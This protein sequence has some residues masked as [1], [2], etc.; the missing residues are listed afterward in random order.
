M[1]DQ[2]YIK[3]LS[4]IFYFLFLFVTVVACDRNDSKQFDL[5]LSSESGIDF[6]NKVV[7]GDDANI[8]D[9]LYFYNGGGVSIGDINN[10]SLPDLF[11]I[12]NQQSNA[13]YLNQGD[14]K[15]KNITDQAKVGGHSDWNTGSVMADVN[16]DGFL[17]IYVM[18]VVGVCGFDGR[19]E[20]YINQGDGTFKEEA[21]R[22]GL[23]FDSYSG[24]AAFFDYDKDGDLDMYLLNQA[25]HTTSSYG[26]ATLRYQHNYVSG[27]KLMENQG[28][29]FVDVSEKAGLLGGPIGYG[30]GLGIADFN[31]DG[32]DDIYVGN[33]FHEDDYYYINNG[34]GTFSEQLKKHFGMVSRFSMGND[35]ADINGDGFVD[36]ITLDI[37]PE[38]EK[39]LKASKGDEP[40]DLQKRRTKLGYHPQYM[41]NMLQIN[42]G[43][44]F[45]SEKALISGVAASDWSWSPLFADL[46]QDGIIDLFITTGIHRRPN[47]LDY[48]KFISGKQIRNKL[49][50]THLVDN[51]AINTMPSGIVHN[52]VFQGDGNRFTNMSGEW[53]PIDTLK[54]NGSAYADLDNDGDLD[55]V[56]N[57]YCNSPVIYNNK[58][59]KAYNYLKMRFNYRNENRFGIGTKVLLYNKNKLQ[60]RQLNCTRGFQSSVEPVLHF[61]LGTSKIIDSLIIIW[62]DNS[63]QKHELVDANQTLNISPSENLKQFD[64]ARLNPVHEKWF[65]PPD[66]SKIILVA[67]EEN[68][69]EDFNREKLIPYKISAEGPALAIGDVNGDGLLDVFLGGSKLYA[70]RLFIQIKE[71]FS[72]MEIP[73]FIADRITED[74]DAHFNDLDGDG[75]LDLFVVSAGGEFFNQRPELKDRIYFNDGKGNFTKNEQAVPDYFENGSVA[76][77]TDYDLD[78]DLDIFV[79]GRAVSYRFGEIP[80]SFLLINDGQGNFSLS[81]Q[82]ALKNVGMITDALWCYFSGDQFPGLILV[83][84][85]MSPQFFSNENGTFI[86]VTEEYLPEAIEGLWRTIQPADIDKDGNMDY[87]LGNWGLNS[88]FHGSR[89]F[90]LKMYVDDFDGNGQIETLIAL[91]KNGEYYPINS[92][93]ELDSQLEG[94]IGE[95]F[96]SYHDFAGKTMEQVF[97]KEA[98]TQASLLN[99]TTLASGYLSNNGESF[100]FIP[101][102][103]ELQISPINRFFVNDLNAD[104]KEDILMAANFLGVSSYHGRF[105]SNTGT[106]LSGDGRILDGLE[107]GINFS[108]KEIRRIARITVDNE[109]Y[110]LAAPNND[111]LLWYKIKNK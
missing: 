68:R 30:L 35:I 85:W 56:I 58:N 97:G 90:S 107:T 21:R 4:N 103:D 66:T 96:L 40:I 105:V 89:K 65:G 45:F 42:K 6:V 24:S 78:G 19:N 26:P 15:F 100:T 93:D 75:D 7:D 46:D 32:W 53:M 111:S 99:A 3:S 16:Q 82:P 8:L 108:Q 12:A 22:Y 69:Y 95:R 11:F 60:T 37:L 110:L 54:S 28:G 38:E 5:V 49:S 2:K 59:S 64:W 106:M 51:E 10:D 101:F 80:N 88:K 17:D 27:D 84:E 47:D 98:L 81:D 9:Y 104:G 57:N 55:L 77:M 36:I 91:E 72:I 61:G 71:G 31:N 83:G 50:K 86:N 67:H 20:L 74:V 39:I 44:E 87:L 41:R 92:K 33:D 14:L 76:R 48:I 102:G 94:M 25:V 13:L 63:Y 70:A 79:G 34:D 73:D 109:D 29:R 43:G 52:Y 18:A 62:P 1:K 23:D